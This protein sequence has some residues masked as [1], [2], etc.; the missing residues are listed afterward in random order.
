MGWATLCCDDNLDSFGHWSHERV[1]LVSKN[2]IPSIWYA[3]ILKCPYLF[4]TPLYS[5]IQTLC[6]AMQWYTNFS[7]PFGHC[8][9][10]IFLHRWPLYKV[11]MLTPKGPYVPSVTKPV[12]VSVAWPHTIFGNF[13]TFCEDA[14]RNKL[15]MSANFMILGATVQKLWVFEVF[16]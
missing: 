9:S 3:A 6:S 7:C 11:K 1:K 15:W 10:W 12:L 4:S 14:S 13:E 8:F 5:G 16:G 2:V